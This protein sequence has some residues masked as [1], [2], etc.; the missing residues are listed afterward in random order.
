M[1]K[2]FY[3]FSFIVLSHGFPTETTFNI[4]NTTKNPSTSLIIKRQYSKPRIVS[5]IYHSSPGFMSPINPM[6]NLL[7]YILLSAGKEIDDED[8]P[9]ESERKRSPD[10]F[11]DALGDLV[12]GSKGVFSRIDETFRSPRETFTDLEIHPH[13]MSQEGTCMCFNRIIRTRSNHHFEPILHP[14]I[15][16]EKVIKSDDLK[17]KKNANRIKKGM[18][19]GVKVNFENSTQNTSFGG[20][21]RILR[22]SDLDG[23]EKI[24][25]TTEGNIINGNFSNLSK[26]GD[27][28]DEMILELQRTSQSG[29]EALK[30]RG[31]AERGPPPWLE[32]LK[33]PKELKKFSYQK[34]VKEKRNEST[35][36]VDDDGYYFLFYSGGTENRTT[37]NKNDSK[38]DPKIGFEF[39]NFLRKLQNVNYDPLMVDNDQNVIL[40]IIKR[41]DNETGPTQKEK[42]EAPPRSKE[43][44]SDNAT[45]NSTL[46][47]DDYEE[48]GE[49]PPEGNH[50]KQSNTYLYS[51]TLPTALCIIIL[52]VGI[53]ILSKPAGRCCERFLRNPDQPY[54][55]R[56]IKSRGAS[57]KGSGRNSKV[58]KASREDLNDQVPPQG[59]YYGKGPSPQ[60][61]ER[62]SVVGFGNVEWRKHP[63]N[64][65]SGL[66]EHEIISVMD[67]KEYEK[68]IN[69]NK[70]EEKAVPFGDV[71]I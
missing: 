19:E 28:F 46:F 48:D 64:D 36:K 50:E 51:V 53:C 42:E 57:P 29:D 16:R 67:D 6:E 54:Q 58:F 17:E 30:K 52:I 18:D 34:D 43:K 61:P 9:R 33:S 27:D 40:N 12:N 39:A 45:S 65:Y 1:N 14:K 7:L 69:K 68:E 10:I 59:T 41:D 63:G 37:A 11:S 5:N 2:L 44:K 25:K 22:V 35:E 60:P 56:V 31:N 3:I 15:T 70:N 24:G 13:P 38:R 49:S 8:F 26:V 55:E 62:H 66:K 32:S 20:A 23:D 71:R 21:V 4:S 47:P